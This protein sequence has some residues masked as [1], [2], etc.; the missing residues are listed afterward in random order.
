M[1]GLMISESLTTPDWCN[2]AD[3]G[4]FPL[5]LAN[6][7]CRASSG[8]LPLLM[9]VRLPVERVINGAT[10]FHVA[11]LTRLYLAHRINTD[12]HRLIRVCGQIICFNLQSATRDCKKT[13]R[14]PALMAAGK[15]F[16]LPQSIRSCRKTETL[17]FEILFSRNWLGF[18]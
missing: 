1:A 18:L 12:K 11:R 3:S 10:S 16:S 14:Q 8:R 13:C 5:R 9:P 2:E 6:S 17:V 4:S 7:P 15:F